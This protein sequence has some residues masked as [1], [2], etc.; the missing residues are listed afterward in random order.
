M[1]TDE[2]GYLEAAVANLKA[3]NAE[4]KQDNDEA[5]RKERARMVA[6]VERHAQSLKD[7]ENWETRKRNLRL[8]LPE[9][10]GITYDDDRR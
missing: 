9:N 7:W 3:A 6:M 8:G 1:A 5:E 2:M 10:F 4:L